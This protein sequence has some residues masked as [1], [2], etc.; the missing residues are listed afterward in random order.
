MLGC[1]NEPSSM[2]MPGLWAYPPKLE[3]GQNPCIGLQ[4]HNHS[5][6]YRM[7]EEDT[8]E[9]ESCE[10]TTTVEVLS[11][12]H[13]EDKGHTMVVKWTQP[14]FDGYTKEDE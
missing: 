1:E 5:G 10:F 14:S 12:N 7:T 4:P 9:C 2:A 13:E 11:E 6:G 3:D 8:F